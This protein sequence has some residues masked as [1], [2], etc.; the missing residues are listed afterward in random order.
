M[1]ALGHPVNLGTQFYGFYD[2]G[3]TWNNM[4]LDPDQRLSS[5]GMGVR[6]SV[7]RNTE[8]DL[9]GVIRN[10]RVP[11]GTQGEVSALKERLDGEIVEV[12]EAPF[13]A[14]SSEDPVREAIELLV[15]DRQ[16]LLVTQDGRAAGLVTRADLLEALAS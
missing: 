13:A 14:V 6:L 8:F 16:A 10:T 11:S 9:E 2:R 1:T 4:L 15:G 7:T 3:E 12:M 5:E